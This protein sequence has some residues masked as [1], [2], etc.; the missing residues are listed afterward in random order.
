MFTLSMRGMS[1][2]SLVERV[3]KVMQ[4]GYNNCIAVAC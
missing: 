4:N 1:A 2:M 3:I